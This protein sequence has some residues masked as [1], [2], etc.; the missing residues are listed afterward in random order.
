MDLQVSKLV[1]SGSATERWHWRVLFSGGRGRESD[2]FSWVP[3]PGRPASGS[4]IFTTL[5]QNRNFI[6]AVWNLGDLDV[7]LYHR[8]QGID[9]DQISDVV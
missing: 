1:V 3:D 5:R 8:E 2:G 4:H 7:L 9:N 6:R